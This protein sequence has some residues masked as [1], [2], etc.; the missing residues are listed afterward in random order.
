MIGVA[1][2]PGIAIAEA[3]VLEEELAYNRVQIE[4]IAAEKARLEE[5]LATSKDE[6][7][8]LKKKVEEEMGSEQAEIFEAHLMILDDPELISATEN[9]LE[10]ESINV[11][12]ALE[13]T[14][15]GFINMFASTDNQYLQE[16]AN[17]I[18]DIGN[19]ILRNLL[20]VESEPVVQLEKEVILI[21]DELTPTDIARID[22]E[23]VLGFIT[24]VGGRTS[25]TAIM[26]RSLGIPAVVG[27]REIL[28]VIKR[29]SNV[30]VDAVD[31]I[32]VVEP[33]EKQIAKYQKKLAGYQQRKEKLAQLK[34][35]SAETED[36][37][38]MELA[39][40]I[41]TPAD[42]AAALASGV[43]GIGLYR[44][45]FLYMGR[46]ALP[47]EEEQFEAYKEVAE[48]VDGATIIRTLDIGGDKELSYLDL[49]VEMN[50]FLGY[51]AIRISLER[52][53]IFKTQ[54]R[55]IL[56]ASKY[57]NVKIMYPMIS[58]LEELQAANHILA[59]VKEDLVR[60]GIEF[61]LELE[62]GVM[63]EV[64]A[65]AMIIDLLAQEADFFSIGTND[66]IQYMTATDRR[67]EKVAG[68]YQPFHPAVL[69]LIKQVVEVA[70]EHDSWVGMCGE[71]A[72]D[73]RLAPFLVGVGLDELS[74]SA[75]SI[76][77]VKEVIRKITLQEAKEVA[78]QVLSLSQPQNI[79]EFLANYW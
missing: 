74:M 72:G 5:A 46:E 14:I 38:R 10:A 16:R 52:T 49:P 69:R 23:Q 75:A 6:L 62:V 8:A 79:E 43:E 25:H 60:E 2:S 55:A 37:H 33:T 73:R 32:V 20:G 7:I 29:G 42:V 50:P 39:A 48:G 22:Q 18:R 78:E 30:I 63:I 51:R 4:D 26:A 66:L 36:G 28:E 70:H 65:A 3:L 35:L 34:D 21:A 15:E 44:S 71:M 31:G 47:T 1:A 64:P 58:S 24:K 41:G 56:R 19:R 45:E 59:E 67:N 61:N 12:A 54:L 53:D 57:G 13:E 76:A 27:V 77:E 11:E 40:N 9:K 17:D 68:L